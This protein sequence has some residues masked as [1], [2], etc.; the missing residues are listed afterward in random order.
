MTLAEIKKA[1]VNHSRKKEH[2]RTC[3]SGKKSEMDVNLATSNVAY[4]K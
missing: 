3:F 1:G 4:Y 2:T